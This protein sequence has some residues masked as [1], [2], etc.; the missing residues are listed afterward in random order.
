[1][2]NKEVTILEHLLSP[3]GDERHAIA[4]L[5]EDRAEPADLPRML[6]DAHI[7]K[8]MAIVEL[9]KRV[10]YWEAKQA[11]LMGFF[12]PYLEAYESELRFIESRCSR[13]KM[14][15]SALVPAGTELVNDI[16]S[17]S[18][19]TSEKGEIVDPEAI[20][21]EYC[22]VADPKPS[23]ELLKAA[24]KKNRDLKIPGFEL[25]KNYNLQIKPGGAKAKN[26]AKARERKRLEGHEDTDNE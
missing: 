7:Q 9:G 4:A 16:I 1:M 18:W 6:S 22:K 23:L 3:Q 21:L 14:A 15:I 12:A 24:V 17:V 2:E 5:E 13:A 19:R 25:K 20:P 10:L 26:N 8:E 11:A